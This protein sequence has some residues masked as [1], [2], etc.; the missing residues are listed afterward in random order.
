MDILK[1]LVEVVNR[2]KIRRIELLT[3]LPSDALLNQLYQAISD[4]KFSNDEEASAHFYNGDGRSSAYANL[5]ARLK[6]RLYNHL[7]FI[8]TKK[9]SYT[10]R[11]QAYYEAFRYWAAAKI[12]LG[13]N[14]RNA[15]VELSYKIWKKAKAFEFTELCMD[16]AHTLRLHYGGR[17][18][19]TRQFEF[20]NKEYKRYYALYGAENEAEEAYSRIMLDYVHSK[21]SRKD[22]QAEIRRMFEHLQS[23]CE[24][25]DSYRLM[26][27]VFL[28]ELAQYSVVNEVEN[29]IAVARRMVQYFEKKEY[30]ASM[31]L[32]AGYYQ[33]AYCYLQ[34]GDYVKGR[35]ALEACTNL[36]EEGT[37]NWFKYQEHL[38][39]LALRTGKYQEGFEQFQK[40]RDQSRFSFQSSHIQEY[41][42]ILEAYLYYLQLIQ[43]INKEEKTRVRFRLG[44]FLNEVPIYSQDKQGVNIAILI[45]QILILL[46][47]KQFIDVVARIEAIEKYCSRHLLQDETRR[48]YYFIKMLLQIPEAGF[49][50][51]AVWRKTQYYRK[52]LEKHSLREAGPSLH[53][54]FIPYEQIWAQLQQ[55]LPDCIPRNYRSRTQKKKS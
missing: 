3:D 31:P 26:L 38:V 5:K 39:L 25:Y 53:S 4:G 21:A 46:V 1:E 12:L 16:I 50:R 18:G 32:T 23:Y 22:K 34:L 8:D 52:Q 43:A 2:E 20:F 15:S 19:D 28:V 29:T 45:V 48:S 35:K 14:A 24:H 13:K 40:V 49:H 10:N 36:V 6:K 42:A 47:K 11:Q 33:L 41:W 30:E 7:F 55:Y 17:A 44:R 51:E 54:E 27:Y 9:P 37:F